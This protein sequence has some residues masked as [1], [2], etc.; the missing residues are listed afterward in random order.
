MR[1][2][3]RLQG[4]EKRT[5]GVAQSPAGPVF[6]EGNGVIRIWRQAAVKRFFDCAAIFCRSFPVSSGSFSGLRK[7]ETAITGMPNRIL[8][9]AGVMPLKESGL[10]GR[11]ST[12]GQWLD[13]YPSALLF[14]ASAEKTGAVARHSLELASLEPLD[15]IHQEGTA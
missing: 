10:T 8:D 12:A 3:E 11:L 7:T 4:N 1:Y 5:A 13:H 6:P 14:L 2:A 9:G 15:P